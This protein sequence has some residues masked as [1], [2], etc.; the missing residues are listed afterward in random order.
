MALTPEEQAELELLESEG[1][2]Q[3]EA[4]ELAVLES[5][6]HTAEADPSSR[7]FVEA[8]QNLS[9]AEVNAKLE[10]EGFTIKEPES[11]AFEKAGSLA[12]GAA[13]GLTLNN[14]D[15][16]IAGSS[17]VVDI[18]NDPD[19]S[20]SD[21][22][23]IYRQYKNNADAALGSAEAT[24]PTLF[25]A[26]EVVGEVATAF[27][28]G[29]AA[30]SKI[31]PGTL[32]A[33]VAAAKLSNLITVGTLRGVGK[34]E[35]LKMDSANAA[36]LAEE[37]GT[38][39]VGFKIGQ[40]LAPG[41]AKIAKS[42]EENIKIVSNRTNALL[43]YVG[44]QGKANLIDF[45][46]RV[47]RRRGVSKERYVSDMMEDIGIHKDMSPAN[48]RKSAS[49]KEGK[50]WKEVE[51]I[52]D[53]VDVRVPKGAV[54]GNELLD[55][56]TN[57]IELSDKFIGNR[58]AAD[59]TVSSLMK[60]FDIIAK[61]N[62]N[63]TLFEAQELKNTIGRSK[64]STEV[65]R[66]VTSAITE[67]METTTERALDP[68]AA[69]EFKALKRRWGNLRE[70]RGF[71]EAS[72]AE[73]Q[74]GI[75]KFGRGTTSLWTR[76]KS[77][78][79]AF[80]SG[81]IGKMSGRFVELL[82]NK[83]PVD[84]PPSERLDSLMKV[85]THVL[86]QPGKYDELVRDVA[87]GATRSIDTFV[88]T[89]GTLESTINL[90]EEPLQRTKEDILNKAPDLINVVRKQS[91][92]TA[93]TLSDLIKRGDEDSYAALVSSL[94]RDPAVK[95]MI[96]PGMGIDGIAYSELDRQE[97]KASIDSAQISNR[98]KMLHREA[99]KP[100]NGSIVPQF[101]E[102]VPFSVDAIVRKRTDK[103]KKKVDF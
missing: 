55:T 54:N 86:R 27:V 65:K 16:M 46:E 73:W 52:F 22:S 34:A 70:T 103:G 89:M 35:N 31:V 56:I 8:A 36:L 57:R 58:E 42:F 95:D 18:A 50:I 85:A 24:N 66:D 72:E 60:E 21:M 17:A 74:D 75:A 2:T 59:K 97:A 1:L 48:I 47:L 14:L 69:R 100:Q 102:E 81:G 68:S 4:E 38:E 3:E 6:G 19:K 91:P 83:A 101:Q 29:A 40:R 23:A 64:I 63:L 37:I 76:T 90:N 98:Q 96:E 45:N 43:D 26:G 92:E 25:G 28:P 7:E 80:K 71:I 84:Y 32:A 51:N 11:T 39:I 49:I 5:E 9:P 88:E 10:A 93:D 13:Q 20:W 67:V 82:R 78:G 62:D 99:S 94:A 12:L 30:V 44:V 79:S 15:E 87:V 41:A 53:E 77:L 61:H 33:R